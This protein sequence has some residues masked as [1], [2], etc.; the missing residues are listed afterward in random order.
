[1]IH[2]IENKFEGSGEVKG[3]LFEKVKETDSG[4]IYSVTKEEA[5]HFEVFKKK[6]TPICLDFEN[7]VYSETEFKEVK[8]NSKSFGVWAW[9][10]YTFD[11]AL[12]KLMSL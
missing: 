9:S 12:D 1:M 2:T 7:K 6:N 10:Y 4:Y 8:P 11:R 3:W 5:K